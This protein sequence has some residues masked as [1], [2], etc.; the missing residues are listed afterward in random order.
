MNKVIKGVVNTNYPL[1]FALHLGHG[2]EKVGDEA[3]VG[4][5]EDG[6]LGVLVDG[7]DELRVLHAGQMLNRPRNSDGDVEFL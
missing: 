5:L 4:D 7:H 6:C 3:E 2:F 1:H